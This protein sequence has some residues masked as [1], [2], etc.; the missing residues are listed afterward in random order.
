MATHEPRIF[1][2]L[3]PFDQHTYTDPIRVHNTQ[4]CKSSINYQLQKTKKLQRKE[5]NSQAQKRL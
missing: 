4:K 1:L 5:K 3:Y 2:Q